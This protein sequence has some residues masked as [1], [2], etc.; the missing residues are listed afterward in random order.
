MKPDR[1]DD[2]APFANCDCIARLYI[3]VCVC[4]SVWVSVWVCM[5]VCVC[6]CIPSFC[7]I[8]VYV[9]TYRRWFNKKQTKQLLTDL[10]LHLGR[11]CRIVIIIGCD[12]VGW[13]GVTSQ[14]SSAEW[15]L[16]S[17]LVSIFLL[18]CIYID[19]VNIIIIITII[20]MVIMMG[21]AHSAIYVCLYTNIHVD[22][23][24]DVVYRR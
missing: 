4:V 1:R 9:N 18:L 5:C 6:V 2:S 24:A 11:S 14:G 13:A 7:I 15:L 20:V 22:I 23:N 16:F 8:N 19:A 21:V 10:T 17:F 12:V 3:R